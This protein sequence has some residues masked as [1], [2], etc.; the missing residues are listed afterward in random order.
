MG[1]VFDPSEKVRDYEIVRFLSEGAFA[2]AYEAR[3]GRKEKVFFKNYISPS[4]RVEWYRGFVDHQQELVKRLNSAEGRDAKS[5]C[6]EFK[7]FFE[8]YDPLDKRRKNKSFFQVFEFIEGGKNLREVLDERDRFEDKDLAL[9]AYVMMQGIRGIQKIKIVHTDLKPENI[10]LIPV[11]TP[12]KYWV[13]I[14]D[15]DW[16]IFSDTQAPWHDIQSYVGTEGYQSPEHLRGEVPVLASDIFTCGIMLG[17]ILGR[18]H[19]FAEAGNEFGKAALAGR[20]RPIRI[21]HDLPG[22]SDKGFVEQIL[23][24]CLDPDPKKRP[25]ADQICDALIGK[26]FPWRGYVPRAD[27]PDTRPPEERPPERTDT[28]I[29]APA[30]RKVD[31]YFDGKLLKSA[32]IDTSF[33]KLNFKDV[34]SDAQ[35]LSDPQF[36]LCKQGGGWVI[37]HASG[38]KNETIVNGHKLVAPVPVSDGMR[39]SVG[40]S[41]KGVEKFTLTLKLNS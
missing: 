9:F 22:V 34:H 36:K 30:A 28:K 18:E 40:N 4:V 13:R 12:S 11:S 19:P 38:V 39:V 24:A 10:I 15:M 27:K 16:A 33:G 17:E 2:Y 41:A 23:N 37:E 35:F 5:R 1:R 32:T 25:T 21:K 7:Q 14:I 29:T 6:Y 26:T 8:D 31:I 20:F 3:N